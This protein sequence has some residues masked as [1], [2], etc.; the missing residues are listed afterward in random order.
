MAAIVDT[1]RP[2]TS[3]VD[4]FIRAELTRR[5]RVRSVRTARRAAIEYEIPQPK[6]RGLNLPC[7]LKG[8]NIG[9]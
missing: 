4:A 6:R 9:E 3:R 5:E 7:W 2:D 8:V 1:G